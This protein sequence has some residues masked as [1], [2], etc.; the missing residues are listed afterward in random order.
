MI[1]TVKTLGSLNNVFSLVRGRIPGQLIIQYTDRCNGRCPQCSMRVTEDFERSK[2]SEEEIK[3]TIASASRQ[4][5]KAISFTGGEPFLYEDEVINLIKY[6]GDFNIKYIRTGTNGFIFMNSE[7]P[8]F[9]DR[10]KCFAEKLSKT[11]LRNFWI[12]IDSMDANTHENM[13]GL[14][15]VIKGVEKAL[16][17]FHEYGI[18]PAANLGINRNTGGIG[19]IPN[20][21]GREEEFY[22]DFRDAFRGFYNFVIDLGFTM[23]N[24]CY[25]MS[26]NKDSKS[27]LKAVYGAN[28]IN[29]V[30]SFSPREKIQ[31]FKALFDTIPEYRSKIRLFTPLVSLYAMIKQYEGIDNYSLPCRGGIDFFFLSVK[32][33]NIY[34]CGFRGEENMGKLYHANLKDIKQKAF[35]R[36]CDWECFRDPSEM[37]GYLINFIGNPL[38]SILNNKKDKIYRKLWRQ[39]IDYYNACELFNGRRNINRDK[40]KKFDYK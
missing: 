1:G 39:D 2:L 24:A 23:V 11:K 15:G 21:I 26:V 16:P 29:N 4:G 31:I 8:D 30:I 32:D 22:N 7:S 17:I 6:A 38:N 28:S 25:P 19:K 40:L 37:I 9:K 34:P 5:I 36:E 13:R 20:N 14:K 10:I 27:Q 18:Y 3:K 12:S 35:C 33:G